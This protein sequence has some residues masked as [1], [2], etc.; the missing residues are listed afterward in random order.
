MPDFV[1]VTDPDSKAHVTVTRSFAERH[2]LTPLQ[3]PAVD[4][5]GKP[6]PATPHRPLGT[7]AAGKTPKE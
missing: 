7:S 1:R 6:L 5:Y 3:Q 2:K 4:R